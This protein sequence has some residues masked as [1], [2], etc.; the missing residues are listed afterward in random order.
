MVY[1]QK[2]KAKKQMKKKTNSLPLITLGYNSRRFTSQ[3]SRVLSKRPNE[4]HTSFD[5]NPMH[6]FHD[7]YTTVHFSVKETQFRSQTLKSKT[8]E[9][10]KMNL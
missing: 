8:K 3:T 1:R 5:N 6:V 2:F 10:M 7:K 9:R 4:K